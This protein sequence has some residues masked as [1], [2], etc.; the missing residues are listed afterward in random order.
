MSN[1]LAYLSPTFSNLNLLAPMA[2]PTLGDYN[3]WY[4]DYTGPSP[5]LQKVAT[6]VAAQGAVL[7][8]SPPAPNVSWTLSFPGPSLTCQNASSAQKSAVLDNIYLKGGQGIYAYL[9][10]APLMASGYNT[11]QYLPFPSNATS[12]A[13]LVDGTNFMT[14]DAT[15]AD[16]MF[17][18]AALSVSIDLERGPTIYDDTDYHDQ[19]S[20]LIQCRLHNGT[21]T[22][23]IEYV[24][25]E[26]TIAVTVTDKGPPLSALPGIWG[27]SQAWGGTAMVT[28][29]H[30][31]NCSTFNT[32]NNA[33]A[34]DV[35]ELQGLSYQAVM[36]AF[37]TLFA[38]AIAQEEGVLEAS[39]VQSTSLLQTK[40]LRFLQDWFYGSDMNGI[41]LYLQSAS[42]LDSGDMFSG[43]YR[44]P[45]TPSDMPLSEALEQLF[46]NITLSLA[47]SP[48]LQ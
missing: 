22:A 43:I 13:L 24:N 29:N 26:R 2:A 40:E 5:A 48:E 20:T 32:A 47:G 25:G 16:T 45:N 6:A 37:V 38:G 7:S 18:L 12:H 41:S 31:A 42:M 19:W 17:Y 21:Y 10:W 3:P 36:H 35:E 27:P 15:T 33:C 4:Y 39:G 28:S 1:D 44:D 9:A 23:D 11:T 30:Q 8:V 34:F 14:F 46:Q